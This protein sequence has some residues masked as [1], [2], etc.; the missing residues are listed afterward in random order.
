MVLTIFELCG[1]MNPF[2]KSSFEKHSK[3]VVCEM[4]KQ[5]IYLSRIN[6][7]KNFDF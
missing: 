4:I 2:M 5:I 6:K 7:K 3:Q 1:L